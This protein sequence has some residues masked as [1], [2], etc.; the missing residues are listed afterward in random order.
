MDKKEVTDWDMQAFAD[1][2][3]P[4]NK[5]DEMAHC[6]YRHTS[7]HG[8]HTLGEC[9]RILDNEGKRHNAQATDEEIEEYI[10]ATCNLCFNTVLNQRPAYG[11][12]KVR[13]PHIASFCAT[14]NK[15]ALLKANYRYWYLPHEI[16]AQNRRNRRF[17]EENTA[18][19]LVLAYYRKPAEGERAKYLNT[20]QIMLRFGGGI[21]LHPNQL[22]RVLKELEFEKAHTRHG[23]FWL[24][25][26]RSTEEMAQILP[27][28]IDDTL[29]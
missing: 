17:E 1:S 2:Y 19:N 16:E 28:P 8:M 23:D 21:K 4:D 18:R 12:Y 14:G 3:A 25:V 27:E 6:V 29:Q 5:V 10:D 7:E 24:L 22:A 20:A 26:E 13:L 15:K 11:H 9:Q